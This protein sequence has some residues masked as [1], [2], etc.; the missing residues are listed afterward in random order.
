M[1]SPATDPAPSASTPLL[2]LERSALITGGVALLVS[3]LLGFLAPNALGGAY[4]FAAFACLA[5]ALGSIVFQLI[6]RLTGGQWG[7]ALHPFLIAGS[8]LLPW[9]WLLTLPLLFFPA[10][11]FLEGGVVH[12]F[13]ASRAM[14]IVR[15][16][17][18]GAVFWLLGRGLGRVRHARRL[19]DHASLRW[20]AP[21]GLIVLV[22]MIHLLAEDW[23]VAL[24][25]GWHSTAFPAVWLS[26][27]ALAGLAIALFCAVLGGA[28]PARDGAAN[29]PLGLDWGNLL[30]A[31]TMFFA[32]VAFAQ[33]LIIWAGN[34]PRETS[35]YRLRT[36]GAWRWVILA[37]AVFHFG[38]PFLFL[39]SRRFKRLPAGLA[40]AALLLVVAQLT[41]L[42]WL[43]LPAFGPLGP[44]AFALDVTLP[45]A[46]LGLF[47]NRYL[48]AARQVGVTET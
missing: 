10:R 3:M 15:A 29:R 31:G 46:A 17:A 4:R 5:L 45:V 6:L 39:L 37:L 35:W 9:V 24:D 26:G 47:L 1:N 40:G 12:D 32:Y 36:E 20:I 14:Q 18:Y 44:R 19:G 2:R 21:A 27:Q 30:L 23:L 13:Y 8:N 48:A 16:L 7:A 33:F 42:A 11:E 22:F 41:Y 38:L 34:L 43:I 28:D 25:P